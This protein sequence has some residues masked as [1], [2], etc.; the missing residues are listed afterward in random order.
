MD[1]VQLIDSLQKTRCKHVL[2]CIDAV[3]PSADLDGQIT[4]SFAWETFTSEI[5]R[6]VTQTDGTPDCNSVGIELD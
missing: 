5:E 1:I 6:K 3:M 4:A 2:L